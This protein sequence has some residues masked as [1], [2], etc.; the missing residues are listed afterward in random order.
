[1]LNLTCGSFSIPLFCV[2]SI[3]WTKRAKTVT[4]TG[5]YVSSRGFEAS[6]ISVK[7]HA[8]YALLKQL[9]FDADSIFDTLTNI[10]TDRKSD[11]GVFYIGGFPIY[12]ELEFTPTNINKTYTT[13]SCTIKIIELDMV[14]SGVKAVK[15]VFRQRALEIDTPIF[16]PELTLTVDG[17]SLNIRDSFQLNEF[18]T[19]PD[20]LLFTVSIGSDMDLRDREGFLNNLLKGTVE[21]TLP[22]GDLVYYIIDANL[23]DESLSVT[24]SIYPPQAMKTLTRTY[25]DTTIKAVLVDLAKEAGIELECLVE[26]KIDYYRAFS[27]PVQCIK[28]I[29]A[30]AGFIISY[31]EGKLTCVDVPEYIEASEKVDYN[32]ME[33]DSNSEKISGV[34]WFDGVNQFTAGE[35]SSTSRKV[36]S[37]F[38][39]SQDYSNRCLNFLR[40]LQNMIIVDTDLMQNVDSHSLLLVQSNNK[41]ISTMCEFYENDWVL[42]T[43]RLELHYIGG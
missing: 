5:G 43:S 33:Q 6:E 16:I 4:H 41:L 25:Q 12:P 13:D 40:Y 26:G 39:S 3:S 34:Y 31:R 8:E 11:S 28:E 42:N 36:Y 21:A 7:I 27:N 38:R 22:Q 30:G 1:M 19:Q 37:P 24:A 20:S 14:F 32:E 10:V 17:K 29:Q 15:E 9:G 35:L 18:I 23:V 2:Q